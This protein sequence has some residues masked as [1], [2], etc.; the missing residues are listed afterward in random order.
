MMSERLEIVYHAVSDVQI[1]DESKFK[2]E[3]LFL[4]R[5]HIESLVSNSI[6]LQEIIIAKPGESLRFAP[7]LDVVEPRAKD[8]PVDNVYP[9]FPRKNS[10]SHQRVSTHVLEGVAIVAVAKLPG[11][12]EGLID[13]QKATIPFCPFAKTLNVVLHFELPQRMPPSA[14]D[15][16]IRL[17]T[18]NIANFLGQL[19]IDSPQQQV[20][21]FNWP[22]PD[23]Q[24]PKAAL[25]YLFNPRAICG[26]HISRANPW[27]TSPL[28]LYPH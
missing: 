22:L 20:E 14:A 18:L 4:K 25:V 19:A 13:M 2:D 27:T 24:L 21:T 9:G 15:E 28:R 7:V 11:V 3:V 8:D 5:L 23:N 12:Q 17:S 1:S 26:G 10:F 16:A 6:R